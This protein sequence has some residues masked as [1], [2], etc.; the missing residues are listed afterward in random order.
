MPLLFFEAFLGAEDREK[1]SHSVSLRVRISLIVH[2]LDSLRQSLPAI[3]HVSDVTGCPFAS[4]LS[5]RSTPTLSASVPRQTSPSNRTIGHLAS[6]DREGYNSRL[7]PGGAPRPREDLLVC[8]RVR[9]LLSHVVS[10][11]QTFHAFAL[12]ARR[13]LRSCDVSSS[14]QGRDRGG[15][16]KVSERREKQTGRSPSSSRWETRAE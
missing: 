9:P 14:D 3:R 11:G 12:S 15:C 4:F 16:E 2:Y 10:R 7:L 6:L 1:S 5:S 13:E 8:R